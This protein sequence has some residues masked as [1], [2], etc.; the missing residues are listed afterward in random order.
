MSSA[1]GCDLDRTTCS[2]YVFKFCV[3]TEGIYHIKNQ[4]LILPHC[5]LLNLIESFISG[6]KAVTSLN[7]K[8][9][10][11]ASDTTYR[12]WLKEQGKD[13]LP[14]P[15]EDLYVFIDNIGKYIVKNYRVKSE[16]NNTA[17]I[18][19]ATYRINGY[20]S[21][22]EDADIQTLMENII[23]EGEERSREHRFNPIS[24]GGG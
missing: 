1:V 10:T 2:E 24:A 18:V 8:V 3:I 4:N 22:M 19:T 23:T 6:S 20:L 17:N 11:C 5:F 9:L 13:K 16:K 7:G 15:H 14:T 12:N 21:E